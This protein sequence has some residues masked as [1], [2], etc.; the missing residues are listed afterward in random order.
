MG[1]FKHGETWAWRSWLGNP[2]DAPSTAERIQ[3]ATKLF[4]LAGRWKVITRITASSSSS[5][6]LA[7]ALPPTAK[8]QQDRTPVIAQITTIFVVGRRIPLMSS[9]VSGGNLSHQLVME[10]EERRPGLVDLL[11]DTGAGNSALTIMLLAT[12]AERLAARWD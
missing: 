6:P 5:A 4:G 2:A 3:D 8:H 12:H 1:I 9:T 10:I 11:L 7:P